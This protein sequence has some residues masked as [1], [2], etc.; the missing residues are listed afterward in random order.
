MKKME[1][2]MLS[3]KLKEF[4]PRLRTK[5][6]VYIQEKLKILLQDEKT[7]EILV[8]PTMKL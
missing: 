6:I 8:N 7:I 5:L 2:A 4:L 1:N 3:V